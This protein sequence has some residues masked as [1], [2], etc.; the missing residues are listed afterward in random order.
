[1]YAN[2]LIILSTFKEELQPNLNPI[3]DYYE[4][5]KL[6]IN[7][8]TTKC[9]TFTNDTHKEKLKMLRNINI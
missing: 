6:D 4:K 2:D 7:Y 5:W 8:V 3:N 1:M 9:I